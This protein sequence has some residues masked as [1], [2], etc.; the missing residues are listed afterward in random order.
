MKTKLFLLFTFLTIS[1]ISFSQIDYQKGYFLNNIGEKTECF[2]KNMDWKNNPADFKYRLAETGEIK[3]AVLEDV[4]EFL[5]YDECKFVRATTNIDRSVDNVNNLSLD[6]NPVFNEEQLFLRVVVEGKATLYQ[7]QDSNLTRFFYSIG[8]VD[9]VQLIYKRFLPSGSLTI[10]RNETYKEQLEATMLCGKINANSIARIN[11]EFTPLKKFFIN[12]NICTGSV[13]TMLNGNSSIADNSSSVYDKNNSKRDVFNLT[14]RIGANFS[15]F[16]VITKLA[17]SDDNIDY[18]SKTNARIG[19]ET[20]FILPYN[21]NKIALIAEVTFSNFKSEVNVDNEVKKVD[22]NSIDVP[23]G[24]RY[25]FFLNKSSKI[26]INA[27]YNLNVSTG[28]EVQTKDYDFFPSVASNLGYGLGYKFKNKFSL[29]YRLLSS[30]N[31]SDYIF[32]DFNYKV[33]SLI[34]GYSFF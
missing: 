23:F 29:E 12:Y 20:E 32:Y 22:Y 11:Y 19:L 25:Y 16:E 28:K 9:K 27:V 7:Y 17:N 4:S 21:K 14:P 24:V 13:S 6:I 1:S 15:S 2:I 26:Y 8:E 5:I 3:T 33:S 30:R 31:A 10:G 34:L 18:G